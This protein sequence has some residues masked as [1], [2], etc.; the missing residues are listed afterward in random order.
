MCFKYVAAVSRQ[1]PINSSPIYTQQ[2]QK[3]RQ[4]TGTRDY[5]WSSIH[6]YTGEKEY[7]KG[8]TET[9]FV[10]SIFH[11]RKVGKIMRIIDLEDDKAIKNVMLLLTIEEASE[12]RN[13][14]EGILH[15]DILN[16]HAHV[17]DAAYEHEITVAIY[18]FDK[19]EQFNERTKRLILKDE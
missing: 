16:D 12:L 19:I 5:R 9:G 11:R 6:A 7:L 18:Q 15:Q 1:V 14:L 8:L 4:G 13:D 2:S 10:L 17:N 3:S